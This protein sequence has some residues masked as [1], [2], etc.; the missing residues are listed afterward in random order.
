MY[1]E[2]DTTHVNSR[3]H[4]TLPTELVSKQTFIPLRADKTQTLHL[5]GRAN[6]RRPSDQDVSARWT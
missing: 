6:K 5:T 4:V 2:F 3:L 1:C